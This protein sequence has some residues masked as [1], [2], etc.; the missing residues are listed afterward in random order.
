MKLE[1]QKK[2]MFIPIAQIIILFVWYAHG[3]K[4]EHPVL[5]GIKCM[6]L[7][8][9]TAP[10]FWVLLYLCGKIPNGT[11]HIVVNW[12]IYYLWFVAIDGILIS[13]QAKAE[14]N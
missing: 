4:R 9:L 6:F 14:K 1:T 10:I 7:L 3:W 8:L 12:V 2:I 13:N 11:I 5:N